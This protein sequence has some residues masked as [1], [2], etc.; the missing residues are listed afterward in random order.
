MK[1]KFDISLNTNSLYKSDY[2]HQIVTNLEKLD[3]IK[4]S[5]FA[6]INQG[7]SD[8]V[9][10]LVNIKSRINRIK[11]IIVLF[12]NL[13][14]ALTIKSKK[15]Y[16]NNAI[17][18]YRALHIEEDFNNLI[19]KEQLLNPARLMNKPGQEI[20]GL[21]PK[22]SFDDALTTQKIINNLPKFKDLPIILNENAKKN[23]TTNLVEDDIENDIV[24]SNMK[25]T[26]S[27]FSFMEKK[28]MKAAMSS[29][30]SGRKATT[31]INN[32]YIQNPPQKKKTKKKEILQDAPVSIKEKA[33]ISEYK[34][35]RNFLPRTNI[36][37][38]FE[39]NLPSNLNLGNL[40]QIDNELN[41]AP[42]DE[43]F[44]E[45]DQ[46]Q[47]D[48]HFDGLMED[49]DLLNQNMGEYLEDYDQMPLDWVAHRNQ[50]ALTNNENKQQVTA[51]SSNQE[52]KTNNQ[53]VSSN[54]PP[55][56][57]PPINNPNPQVSNPVPMQPVAKSSA[58]P[59]PPPLVIPVAKPPAPK[60]APVKKAQPEPK[61]EPVK[62]VEVKKEEK[63]EEEKDNEGE[64]EKEE[65]K[66][67]EGEEQKE[68]KGENQ[69]LS[70]EE[71]IARSMKNL[72]KVNEV[73]VEQKVTKKKNDGPS[74]M[75]LL[76]KQIQWR[77][78]KLHENDDDEDSEKS[79]W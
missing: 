73:K 63:K 60:N 72:K 40:A 38:S 78:D 31:D 8:R 36:Q 28:K 22:G 76:K 14:Q 61:K 65:D 47:S 25:Y 12:N 19:A 46:Q 43:Y 56:N 68:E 50:E 20:L 1:S 23:Y 21:P 67:K 26:N 54:N 55:Q 10:K 71:E 74:M 37:P 27:Q 52:V 79:D 2:F 77:Y 24:E 59:V 13:P 15:N 70:M 45:N 5:I 41:N 44:Q 7:I 51:P 58:I 66:E 69:P 33:K 29:R 32:S 34:T 39:V 11:Q 42:I 16:P 3:F 75:D 53:P 64:D 35:K 62:E 18:F 48:S 4:S 49:V 30:I 57:Q 17:N 9:T 6:T